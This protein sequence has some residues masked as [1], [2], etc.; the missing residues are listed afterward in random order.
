MI[1]CGPASTYK[2]CR[3][4]FTCTSVHDLFF[5]HLLSDHI[6]DYPCFLMTLPR[7]P[8]KALPGTERTT[9]IEANG[10]F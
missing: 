8:P 5:T 10:F 7:R 4:G 9:R 6:F 2:L 1:D 3:T